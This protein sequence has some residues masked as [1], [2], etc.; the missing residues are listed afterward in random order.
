MAKLVELR[1]SDGT[2]FNGGLIYP[3]TIVGQIVDLLDSSGK[4]RLNL[5]SGALFGGAKNIGALTTNIEASDVFA[6]IL[7]NAV[8]LNV[9]AKPGI[10]APYS[11]HEDLKNTLV[12]RYF[13]IQNSAN[14]YITLALSSLSN[15]VATTKNEF[16]AFYNA[17]NFPFS[18]TFK[19][20]G[21][22][23]STPTSPDLTL[24]NGDFLVFNN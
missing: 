3:K 8:S 13:Q 14:G 15:A 18:Y 4:V 6:K 2:N 9:V 16:I 22:D 11:A 23:G 5:L 17:N 24:E 12:G 21:D 10:I 20:D 19:F 7:E 1:V